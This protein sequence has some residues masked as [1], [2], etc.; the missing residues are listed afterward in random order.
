MSSKNIR[1][2]TTPDACIEITKLFSSTADIVQ[3]LYTK[4]EKLKNIPNKTKLLRLIHGDVYCGTRLLKFGLSDN[5]TCIRCF[6]PETICHL[7]IECPYTT[8]VWQQLGIV[9]TEPLDILHGQLT[10]AEL[11]IRAEIVS[12]IV[13]RKQIVDPTILVETTLM[14]FTRGLS[15]SKGVT[16][17]ATTWL[18]RLRMRRA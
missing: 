13:F 10:S 3:P 15:Q 17:Y 6:Q 12:Q 2:N 18:T 1:E 9:C 5:D 8:R 14:R 16:Q 4:I 7:L 11:E